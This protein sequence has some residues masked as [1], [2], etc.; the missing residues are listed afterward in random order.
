M[1]DRA[2]PNDV[3]RLLGRMRGGDEHAVDELMPVVYDEL[4]VIAR[5][6]L[7]RNVAHPT[8]NTTALVHEAF[9]KLAGSVQPQ[10]QDRCHFFAVAATA[11]RQIL[12][13]YA[14]RRGA[15]KRGGDWKQVDFEVAELDIDHQGELVL[16]IDDALRKLSDLSPRLTQVVECRFFAG[17]SFEETGVVLGVN[18]KTVRRDWTKAR[19]WLHRELGV[20]G[21]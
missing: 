17:M 6:Q 21:P 3:T 12:V 5:R 8:L 15:R 7:R 1:I 13:D 4:R 19:A 11:M 10:W 16:D 14:R 2:E 20:G 9:L 18:E